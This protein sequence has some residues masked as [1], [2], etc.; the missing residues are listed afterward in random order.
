MLLHQLV[1]VYRSTLGKF[2]LENI[3]RHLSS[4]FI[5]A[6]VKLTS[7][8]ESDISVDGKSNLYQREV[9]LKNRNS[10]LKVRLAIGGWSFG[11]AKFKEMAVMRFWRQTFIF[12]AIPFLRKH[13]FDGLGHG[14]G[15]PH[16]RRP[17]HLCSFAVGLPLLLD[18][19][20]LPA[21]PVE[22]FGTR[23]ED[24]ADQAY[25]AALS[26]THEERD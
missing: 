24:G 18:R 15:V 19:V 5:F 9:G 3:D 2:L 1:S 16:E 12:S 7:F 4:R 13:N 11:T 17:R 14:L 21:K 23:F 25:F 20:S 22:H 10:K 8:E 26:D 6:F